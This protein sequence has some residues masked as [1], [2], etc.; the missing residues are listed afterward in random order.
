[1]LQNQVLQHLVCE[2]NPI[3]K[4]NGV[5]VFSKEESIMYMNESFNQ[6]VLNN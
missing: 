6:I 4:N 3:N 5:A 1:M 2:C